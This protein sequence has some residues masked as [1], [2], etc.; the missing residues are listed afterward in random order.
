MKKLLFKYE[1]MGRSYSI[2]V[3]REAEYEVELDPTYKGT[4]G[5]VKAALLQ[6]IF[7]LRLLN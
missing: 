5:G 4:A 3:G 7:A 1:K 2:I 6:N